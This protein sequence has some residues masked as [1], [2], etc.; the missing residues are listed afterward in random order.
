MFPSSTE[1]NN[2]SGYQLTQCNPLNK[3]TITF[4]RTW[5]LWNET[6]IYRNEILLS[7]CSSGGQLYFQQQKKLHMDPNVVL[8]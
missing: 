1:W 6:K 5:A 3:G 4:K 8:K 2:L 7:E